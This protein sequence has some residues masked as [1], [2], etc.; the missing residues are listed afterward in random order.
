[1]LQLLCKHHYYGGLRTREKSNNIARRESKKKKKKR[2]LA[3]P[4]QGPLTVMGEWHFVFGAGLL[5]A[6]PDEQA[7]RESRC[8]RVR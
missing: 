6:A 3:A 1:M 5:A 7:H 4:K 2:D 8:T